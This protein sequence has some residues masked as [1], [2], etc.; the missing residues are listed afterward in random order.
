MGTPLHIIVTCTK[1]K[2]ADIPPALQL[3]NLK[4]RTLAERARKWIE[5]LESTPAAKLPADQ[6]Y[7]GDHWQGAR[8]LR[9]AAANKGFQPDLRVISTGYGLIPA[10]AAIKPY[11]ATFSESHADTICLNESGDESFSQWW[12]L[13]SRW[14]GPAEH[15][16]RTL[17]EIVEGNR[18]ATVLLVASEAYL[19]AVREDLERAAARLKSREQL[20]IVS[21]GTKHL[22]D[23]TGSLMP[24]DARAQAA[25]GGARRS[26]NVRMAEWILRHADGALRASA[27]QAKCRAWLELQPELQIPRRTPS[28][29][30]DVRAFVTAEL[31]RNPRAAFTPLLAKFRSGN[32][33]CEQFRFRALFQ[34][35]RRK[36]HA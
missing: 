5:R 31:R 23:L 32:R 33:A 21:G 3:R 7:C 13:L 25:L 18:S 27:V 28:T 24:V 6:L 30:G 15:A 36:I 4:A 12:E 10:N 29:D 11:M 1:R 19:G 2:T 17:A 22:G 8:R 35:V 16:P 9:T 34:D 26:L 20:L 14:H